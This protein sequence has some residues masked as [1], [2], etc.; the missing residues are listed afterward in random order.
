MMCDMM[1]VRMNAANRKAIERHEAVKSA[2]NIW[3]D[4]CEE[5]AIEIQVMKS[6]NGT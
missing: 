3:K 4:L 2:V 6:Q 5:R 1:M